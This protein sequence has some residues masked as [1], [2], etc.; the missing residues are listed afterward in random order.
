[1]F[2]PGLKAYKITS[3]TFL[4]SLRS[5]DHILQLSVWECCVL[6]F[7]SSMQLCIHRKKCE[8]KLHE[9]NLMGGLSSL[10]RE[11][12]FL[13]IVL[14]V[15]ELKIPLGT[16][17]ICLKGG[18]L[19]AKPKRHPL[20]SSTT[21]CVK[22]L[23]RDWNMTHRIWVRNTCKTV[24]TGTKTRFE[25]EAK[26]NST[27]HWLK[28]EAFRHKTLHQLSFLKEWQNSC[29]IQLSPTSSMTMSGALKWQW[30]KRICFGALEIVNLWFSLELKFSE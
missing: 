6:H 25:K 17:F 21:T 30:L 4:Q 22:L 14:Y 13:I 5:A 9:I 27:L 18:Y 8:L 3:N 19:D 10:W 20:H 2:C 11:A 29:E 24:A 28:P 26:G 16:H 7:L 1:M 15:F 23:T 12:K